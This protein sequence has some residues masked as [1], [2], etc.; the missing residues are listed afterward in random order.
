MSTTQEQVLIERCR[1]GDSSAFGLLI[2]NY[3]RQL[4]SYLFK[5]S[6][7]RTQAEDLFQ[8]MLIK[9]W[10]GIKKYNEQQKFSSW[11][12]TIAHN[13]A[14]DNIRKRKRDEAVSDVEPD[15]LKSE[16]NPLRDIVNNETK[17]LLEKAVLK[18]S[19]KQKDVF[20][21]R[22][23]SQMSFKEIAEISGEPVNTVLSHMNY[24]VKKIKIELGKNND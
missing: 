1:S 23:Y 4:F 16:S 14:M 12:F 17:Q 13:A 20:L 22:I 10:K 7:D 9:T 19:S 21:L 8:E 5:L 24:A 15:K 18:L 11:L 6:G 2:K 3:R